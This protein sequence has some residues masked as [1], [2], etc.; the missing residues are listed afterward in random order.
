MESDPETHRSVR[1]I[2][3][4]DGN[5]IITA[6]EILSPTN[7]R[8]AV[9]R[10]KY[11]RQQREL[12]DAAANLVEIDLLRAGGYVLAAPS[13][14]LPESHLEPYR[15]C[16]VRATRPSVAEVYRFPLRERL[17]AIRIP[18]RLTDPDVYL[19]LQSL[20]DQAYEDGDYATI[21]YRR[22]PDPPLTGEDAEWADRL[23]R[24]KGVR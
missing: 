12:L 14:Q 24:E 5:R 13:N 20:L 2:D 22:D 21:N 17:P 15:A 18:L 8:D 23:L 10:R 4:S 6:I 19:D 7:K 1:I 16:V 9:G 11:R 3:P